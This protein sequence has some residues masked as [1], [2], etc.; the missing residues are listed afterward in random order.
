MD[1]VATYAIFS[2][3]VISSG[4][5]DKKSGVYLEVNMDCAEK[6]EYRAKVVVSN[7]QSES[8][9]RQQRQVF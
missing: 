1:S 6:S 5:P 4:V 7:G 8:K 3:R 9:K 2:M